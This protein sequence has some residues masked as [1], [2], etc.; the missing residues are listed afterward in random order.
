MRRA[1]VLLGLLLLPLVARAAV[2]LALPPREA[3]EAW[4]PA[5]RLGGFTLAPSSGGVRAELLDEG[6]TWRLRVHATDGELREARVPAP[7]SAADREDIVWL[8]ASLVRAGAGYRE[9]PEPAGGVRPAVGVAARRS[10]ATV[11]S[12]RVAP[13]PSV[14][15]APGDAPAPG[16]PRG[17]PASASSPDLARVDGGPATPPL[18]TAPD[19]EAPPADPS[20]S[21]VASADTRAETPVSATGTPDASAGAAAAE[22]DPAD[23]V[24]P[25][26][27]PP[28][29][30]HPWAAVDVGALA[31]AGVEAAPAVTL[32]AGAATAS[33]WGLAAGARATTAAE[34]VALGTGRDMQ[35]LDG[36]V[37]ASWSP[38]WAVAP[39]ATLGAGGS[40]RRFF[41][42]GDELAVAAVPIATASAGVSARLGPFARLD[43]VARATADLRVTVGRVGADGVDVSVSPYTFGLAAGLRFGRDP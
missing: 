10:D 19:S 42:A 6:A 43:V 17:D 33:G 14:A 3:A 39:A 15:P 1:L 18:A 21:E 20:A 24:A 31:R 16:E 28:R 25:P 4:L 13:A 29:A 26:P 37:L 12:A 27:S 34:I 22:P 11:A 7:R 35:S 36:V 2:P 5:A 32:T 23:I 9:G 40:L 8:A 41:D 30:V 38:G